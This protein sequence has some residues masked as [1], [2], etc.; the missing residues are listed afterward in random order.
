[1]SGG[2]VKKYSVINEEKKA[3]NHIMSVEEKRIQQII[4]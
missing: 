1:M 4:S 2:D 3:F